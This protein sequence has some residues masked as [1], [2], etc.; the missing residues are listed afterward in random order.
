MQM[1][2]AY[3]PELGIKAV[4][5]SAVEEPAVASKIPA[6]NLTSPVV[7]RAARLRVKVPNMRRFILALLAMAALA[8]TF[9]G[10][11]S[12]DSTTINGAIFDFGASAPPLTPAQQAFF[13]SYKNAVNAHDE[14][15][16]LAL[17]D[18]SRGGCKFDGHQ[19][20]L[21]DLRFSIPENAKVRFFPATPDFS[22][23]F[24]LG[25]VAYLPIAPTATLGISYGSARKDHISSTEILRPIRQSGDTI[26][27]VPYCLTE[28]GNQLLE[29]KTQS[30]K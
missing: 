5:P 23:A 11:Q 16:L 22:K 18:S 26:T 25:D 17:E 21:R 29:Q 9:M 14:R 4:T 2:A 27:L 15:A 24:G 12:K 13:N 7:T 8:S 1:R 10:A 30:G 6:G 19:I 28:K 20:L 3:V